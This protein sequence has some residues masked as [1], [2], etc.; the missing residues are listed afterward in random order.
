MA[1][2]TGNTYQDRRAVNKYNSQFGSGAQ[3]QYAY[4]H[5]EDDSSFQLVDTSKTHKPM[6]QRGRFNRLNQKL[7]QRQRQQK[8]QQQQMQVGGFEVFVG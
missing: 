1:D 5:E 2:W 7:N 4:I 6:Y 3:T 8:Q